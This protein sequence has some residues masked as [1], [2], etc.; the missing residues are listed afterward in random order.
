M[1]INSPTGFENLQRTAAELVRQE[2]LAEL[3]P[4]EIVKKLKVEQANYGMDGL[5]DKGLRIMQEKGML[6][7]EV[8]KTIRAELKAHATQKLVPEAQKTEKK[9]ETPELKHTAKP[10]AAAAPRV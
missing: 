4:E 10:Q 9:L 6:D 2:K 3:P 8:R 1:D 7:P 5:G